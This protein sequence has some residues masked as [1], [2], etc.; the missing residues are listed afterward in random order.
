MHSTEIRKVDEKRS[1]G[2]LSQDRKADEKLHWAALY[3]AAYLPLVLGGITR[4]L[5]KS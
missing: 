1:C 2:S 3:K 4:H 5:A